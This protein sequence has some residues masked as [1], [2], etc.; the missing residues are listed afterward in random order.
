MILR[1]LRI[2]VGERKGPG[3]LRRTLGEQTHAL[4]LTGMNIMADHC[5]AA[6]A[7]DQ[8]FNT[9]G[10]EQR[11]AV[12]L[13]W[14]YI[15]GGPT[16]STHEKGDHSMSTVAVGWGFVT[17]HH[18]LF[19]HTKLRNPRLDM[20]TYDF[21]NNVIYNYVG[22]GYGS[23]N[24]TRRLNYI[25]NLIKKGPNTTGDATHAFSGKGHHWQAYGEGN[26]LPPDFQAVFEAPDG[27]GISR[28]HPFAPVTTHTAAEAYR[29]VLAQGGA[30]KP[31]RDA[32]TTYVAQSVRD[33][34]GSVP[35]TPDDWPHGGFPTYPP[36]KAPA[37]KNANGVPDAWEIAHGLDPATSKATG[38]DLDARYDNIEVYL[39]SL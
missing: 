30:T 32:I 1:H 4:D 27:V 5:E 14:S 15:Y 6:Y 37:D 39:N 38:R 22:T 10:S 17:L 9:Y 25:G 24:D 19:A 35:G 34:T 7:N 21:R 2:R 8:I 13:Q 31:V 29:L 12:T 33:G 20:L 18:N 3:K 26:Q 23:D 11:E 16:R 36:A 28:P